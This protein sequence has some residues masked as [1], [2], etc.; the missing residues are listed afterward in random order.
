[1]R[2]LNPYVAS[3]L[4]LVLAVLAGCPKAGD[5]LASRLQ[6]AARDGDIPGMA[7]AVISTDT[8]RV[9]VTGVRKSGATA[10][11]AVTDRFHVGSNIKAMTATL[12]A[13][14]VES[15]VIQWTST[16]AEV[17]PELSA[18]MRA[19]YRSVSLEQLLA[20]RGGIL[21]LTEP[22]ELAQLPILPA[23]EVQAR[24]QLTAWLLQ[25]PSAAPPGAASKYSNAGYA[26][27]AAMLEK[28]SGQNFATL[29]TDLVLRPLNITPQFDWPAAGGADQP[30]GHER[31]NNRWVPN[32]PQDVEN[33][34]PRVLTPAG[35]LSISVADYARFIQA[36]LRG[37]RGRAGGLSAAGY[38]RL[39]TPIGDFALGWIVRDLGG[40]KTSAHDGSAGT[41][42][43]L[44]AIQPDR[45]RAVV[46]FANA[47]SDVV[48]NN[49]NALA[50]KLFEL[51]P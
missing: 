15:G 26:I 28:K 27:A 29:L 23:D 20:H 32:D 30:W 44:A 13:T 51:T 45:N 49:A 11:I 22:S 12:A 43:A 39:H 40:A 31:M 24:R 47:Y 9:S 38:R 18:S 4:C 35:N 3:I 17:F 46:V 2:S 25:Q 10:A 1:M 19:E 33:Q 41:F 14:L 21:P 42:Y 36:Q 7:A 8:L 34:F 6:M 5:D 16:L 50:I 48:A 37:L